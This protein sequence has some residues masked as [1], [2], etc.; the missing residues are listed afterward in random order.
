MGLFEAS[1]FFGVLLSLAAYGIGVWL[2]RRTGLGLL[3]PLLVGIVITI[4]VL[5]LLDIDYETYNAGAKYLSYLLMPAT[6]C[7]AVPLYQQFH[8]LRRHYKAVLAGIVTGILTSL[9]S[10]LLLA[11]VFRLD[12]AAYVTLL[13]KSITTAIGVALSE[14]MGGMTGVTTAAIV[15]TG[16]F[17]SIM[18]PAFCR[19][20]RLTDP[21][22]QGV[23]FGTAGHVIGTSKANE[24]S[25]LTGAVS[26]LSL[27]VAGLITAVVLPFLASYI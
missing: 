8:L 16:I 3:N 19:I 24:L 2:R 21:V 7:L 26:S 22:A 20:F 9:C 18:G 15:F 1:V 23:A 4:A 10:V 17:A 6:V 27:V 11:L 5:L 12:H 25:P 13:P 14:M